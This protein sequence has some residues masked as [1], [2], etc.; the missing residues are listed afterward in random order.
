MIFQGS[1]FF[2]F[3]CFVLFLYY[4]EAFLGKGFLAQVSTGFTCTP[5]RRWLL[6]QIVSGVNKTV[7]LATL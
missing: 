6:K 3:F 2:V 4:F 5:A 1:Y 7:L